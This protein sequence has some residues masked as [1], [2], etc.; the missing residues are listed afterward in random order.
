MNSKIAHYAL[1]AGACAFVPV[2]ILDGWLQ[3]KATRAM[4]AAIAESA[5]KPL[6]AATLDALAAD[7]ESLLL[8]CLGAVVVWPIK[9]LFRTVFYFLTVKDAIDGVALAALRGAMVHKA[10]D[11]LPEGAKGVRDVMDLTVGRW[12]Y[13]PVSRVILRGERPPATW[14]LPSDDLG[15][16]W[17]YRHAGGAAILDDFAARLEKLP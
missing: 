8:G 3:R 10:L 15:V 9:K 2:P 17:V 14:L 13:S 16:G 4:Y 5:G 7:R 6:D 11:R 1:M 12:Q